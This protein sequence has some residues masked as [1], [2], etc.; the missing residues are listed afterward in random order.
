MKT[1]NILILFLI[2]PIIFSLNLKD[3]LANLKTLESYISEYKTE[4]KPTQSLQHLILAFIRLGKYTGSSW[5]MVAGSI[6][7]DLVDYVKAKDAEHNTKAFNCRTYGDVILPTDKK[8]DFVHLFAV[9][10]GMDYSPNDAALVGWGGDLAQL[11]QDIKNNFKNTTDLNKLIAEAKKYLGVKGQFGEG[12]LNADID[13]PII[14]KMKKSSITFADT[15]K[16]FYDSGDYKNKVKDFAKII[17]PDLPEK[18]KIRQYI[19]DKY[20][21]ESLIQILEC[22]Y[23][24]RKPGNILGCYSPHEVLS[25]FA[26]HRKA[27]IYAFADYLSDNI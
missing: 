16:R 26:N 14:L 4:K 15:I 7:K 12:D 1:S 2:F 20:T 8:M 24:I 19:Y 11:A 17:F 10:N 25:Q 5:S 13:A 18:A 23:G 9:M 3:A 22:R 21:K 6:P 27:A